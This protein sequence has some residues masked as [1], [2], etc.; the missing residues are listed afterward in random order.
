MA[1]TPIAALDERA[2]ETLK[3]LVGV[4]S[5]LEFGLSSLALYQH[6]P[7]FETAKRAVESSSQCQ[8]TLDHLRQILGLLPT[9]YRLA[10]SRPTAHARRGKSSA[11]DVAADA[12]NAAAD[13]EPVLVIRRQPLSDSVDRVEPLGDRIQAFV[14]RVNAFIAAQVEEL[15]ADM[16]GLES[17]EDVRAALEISEIPRAELPESDASLAEHQRRRLDELADRGRAEDE[18]AMK[19]D[20]DAV[21]N[22]PIPAALEGLPRWLIDKVRR[23]ERQAQRVAKRS[24]DAQRQ[25]VYATLPQLSDQLQ[26]YAIVTRKHIFP[27]AELR[28]NLRRAPLKDRLEEQLQLLE[29]LVPFWVTIRCSDGQEYVKLSKAHKYNV[30]KAE[31]K[32]A[33]AAS[34]L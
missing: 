33:L 16:P 29:T 34:T 2:P 26:S 17:D 19:D 9:A 18:N 5:A 1:S 23:N 13:A 10:W 8:F 12:N 31:L 30:V 20:E 6:T 7:D 28:A 24:D 32:R 22:A 4:F 3:A 25:R 14:S 21:L 27:I 15:T 11:A